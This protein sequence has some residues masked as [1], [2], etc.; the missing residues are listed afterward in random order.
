[1]SKHSDPIHPRV[2]DAAMTYTRPWEGFHE[3]V[4]EAGEGVPT[5][6]H[7]FTLIIKSRGAWKI[8]GGLKDM[9]ASFGVTLSGS[10][11]GTDQ[12][13]DLNSDMGKLEEIR[14]ALAAGDRGE[15]DRLIA[16]HD[17]PTITRAGAATLFRATIA[18]QARKTREWIG[19][20]AFDSL[21]PERQAVLID[22]TYQREGHLK[23][24]GP[25]VGAL[26]AA[27]KLDEAADALEGIGGGTS[28][29]VTDNAAY[30]RNPDDPGIVRARPGDGLDRIAGH[31][32]L[33]PEQVERQNPHIDFHGEG[34]RIG[35]FVRI[36]RADGGELEREQNM[37]KT[38]DAPLGPDKWRVEAGDTLTAIGR[39]LKAT[40]GSVVS[41]KELQRL[42]G[43][44]DDE[45]NNIHPGQEIIVPTGNAAPAGT[46]ADPAAQPAPADPRPRGTL[47]GE[48]GVKVAELAPEAKDI[49]GAHLGFNARDGAR[50]AADRGRV[51]AAAE[52]AFFRAP[53]FATL[54]PPLGRQLFAA[55]LQSTPGRAAEL[56]AGA[57]TETGTPPRKAPKGARRPRVR[58]T[59]PPEIAQAVRV[60]EGA[61]SLGRVREAFALRA[62]R[63]FAGRARLDDRLS[64][65]LDGALARS[66]GLAFGA[67]SGAG[68]RR[69]VR[70]LQ[71]LHNDLPRV[72]D[73]GATP[74][75]LDGVA[76]PRTRA[77]FARA[78]TTLG[79]AKLVRGMAERLDRA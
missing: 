47:M 67:R 45:A 18:E 63:D 13:I 68:G 4:G 12:K 51:E 56:L 58:P 25:A 53:G 72:Q 60:A 29:R 28:V 20:E 16:E 30:F 55:A 21:S 42:N 14:K 34:V 69:E 17:F 49:L 5:L 32:N 7:G 27:G 1:M 66:L 26:I 62:F 9:L 33:T 50:V 79:P 24:I 23:K 54:P 46:E 11:T 40:L 43:F 41:A 3:T 2:I 78:L 19:T 61:G 15:A 76:G 6:G 75:R 57:L 44:T 70:A 22:F 73:G 36:G 8:R 38:E 71:A 59:L 64:R 52:E 48:M 39:K 74:L 31:Y 37:N 65:G 77:G 10:D 35:Q